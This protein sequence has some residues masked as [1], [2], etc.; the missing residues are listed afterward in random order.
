MRKDNADNMQLEIRVNRQMESRVQQLKI[1]N[2][3]WNINHL[4][5][6]NKNY[7]KVDNTLC[8]LRSLTGSLFDKVVKS[9]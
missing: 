6:W 8:L 1:K 3:Q 5:L 9:T 7:L 2:N 4:N